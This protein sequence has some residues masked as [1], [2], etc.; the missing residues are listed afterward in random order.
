MDSITSKLWGDEGL[1]HY[2][3]QESMY[4]EYLNTAFPEFTGKS[5]LEIGPGT[6][7][8]AQMLIKKYKIEEYTILDI[9]KNINDSIDNIKS[10]TPETTLHPITSHSFK[11]TFN[12]KYDLIVSNICI[13]ETPKEYREELLNNII[14]NSRYAMI[15]GQLTGDW[16]IGNEYEVWIKSLFNDNFSDVKCK[17][18][19]Y[20]NCYALT[21]QYK[22]KK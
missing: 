16:V 13:P 4:L 15:I 17:L 19:D 20:K 9:E 12:K 3:H 11:T 14:P 22:N 10:L 2:T 8:F 1:G 7:L 18:T 21:G 6:G 5:V